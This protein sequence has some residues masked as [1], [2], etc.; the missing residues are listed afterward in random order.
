MRLISEKDDVARQELSV[1]LESL[2]KELEVDEWLLKKQQWET[3]R[4]FFAWKTPGTEN[5]EQESREVKWRPERPFE[6][7]LEE[8]TLFFVNR[9]RAMSALSIMHEKNFYRAERKG[10]IDWYMPLCDNI[11]GLGKSTLAQNYIQQCHTL[12]KNV[13]KS[14]FQATLTECKTVTIMLNSASFRFLEISDSYDRFMIDLLKNSLKDQFLVPPA[15]LTKMYRS[16]SDFLLDLTSDAGPVF[17][18]IDE[19]G[20]AFETD[21]RSN[22][23]CRSEFFKFCTEVPGLWLMNQNVFFVLVGRASFLSLVGSRP[24]MLNSPLKASPYVFGRLP[25]QMIRE[26]YISD[27][28]KNTLFHQEYL[29]DY[30]KLDSSQIDT[31][32][33]LIFDQT[34]G[35]PRSIVKILLLCNCYEDFF[36]LEPQQLI[37]NIPLF[38]EQ[39]VGHRTA[40]RHLLR[41]FKLQQNVDM[42]KIIKSDSVRQ[43]A[44]EETLDVIASNVGIQWD[45]VMTNANVF[46][47]PSVL[48]MLEYYLNPLNDYLQQILSCSTVSIDY[49]DA[50]EWICLRRFQ[51]L[52]SLKQ[53]SSVMSILPAFFDT[54]L[55]GGCAGLIL[56]PIVEWF[57]KITQKCSEKPMLISSTE[58]TLHPKDCYRLL[59]KIDGYKTIVSKALPKSSS[60]DVLFAATVKWQKAEKVRLTTG[61]SM[62]CYKNTTNFD[63]KELMVECKLFDQIFLNSP[64]LPFEG[65]RLN[66]LIICA[67]QYDKK[68]FKFFHQNFLVVEMSKEFKHIDEVI[69]LDLT[70]REKRADFFGFLPKDLHMDAIEMVI[71]KPDLAM[72]ASSS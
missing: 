50:F 55:F 65:T 56:E 44:K 21:S 12:W 52:F 28:L 24:E 35:H 31:V 33:K 30:Y 49:P 4:T 57:P 13:T 5:V 40:V 39:V 69:L 32:S 10:G 23:Q 14:H 20:S 51:E 26:Q 29:C 63:L 60:P 71:D 59:S 19:V 48:G 17:I 42:T 54:P 58:T 11:F 43:D 15:C 1:K 18:V 38:K 37:D 68:D 64:P 6:C 36:E 46:I 25:M 22:I 7:S 3:E 53:E 67:T 66:V 34:N 27:I 9:K 70:S 2:S 45:G 62:K 8:S 47:H 41:A 72:Q 61:L 16:S